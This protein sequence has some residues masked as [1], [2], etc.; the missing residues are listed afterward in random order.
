M[1][2]G[3]QRLPRLG[4]E[5]HTMTQKV[6]QAIGET[7]ADLV[8]RAERAEA[9]VARLRALLERERDEAIARARIWQ[10]AY[11]LLEATKGTP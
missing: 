9:E 11:R 10:D 8:I 6:G 2:V 1:F 4:Q 5:G 3:W 7:M